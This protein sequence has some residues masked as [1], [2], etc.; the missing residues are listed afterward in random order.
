[1]DHVAVA[2]TNNGASIADANLWPGRR[3]EIGMIQLRYPTKA[4]SGPIP[5]QRYTAI[6]QVGTAVGSRHSVCNL[7][8]ERPFGGLALLRSVVV[9]PSG[10]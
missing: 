7:M 5:H 6:E 1:M 4:L 2:T 8:S 9:H 10:K 3:A